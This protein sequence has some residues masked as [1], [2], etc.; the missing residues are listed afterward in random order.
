[1]A[2]WSRLEGLVGLAREHARRVRLLR[3][4][5]KKTGMVE[6]LS[7]EGLRALVR[8]RGRANTSLVYRYYAAA[9]AHQPALVHHERAYTFAELDSQIDA[10][11]AALRA[12]GIGRGDAVVLMLKNVPEFI[13]AQQGI[14]RIGAA[15]V[16]VSWRSTASELAYLVEHSGARALLF[17]ASTTDAVRGALERAGRRVGS[18]A[19]SVGGAVPGFGS[20]EELLAARGATPVEDASDEGAVVIYTS[21]TT[22]KPKGAVRKF[23]SNAMVQVLSFIAETPMRVGQTHL[24]VCP[25]YHS[26]GFGF[27]GLAYLLGSTVILHDGF[28]PHDF[29][30]ALERHRV[31]HT[32]LVPTMLHRAVALGED[33]IRARDTSHLKAIFTGGAPL[34]PA[35]ARGAMAAFGDKVF[36]FYGA[37]ETGLVTVAT[38]SD[39]RAAPGTIGRTIG[40]NEIA[41][42]AD[43]GRRCAPGEVGELYVRSG[44][45]VEGYHDDPQATAAS[46][47]DGFFTVGDLARQDERG[48][49]FLEGRKRDMIISGGVNVYPTE[50]ESVIMEHPAVA[51]AA[52]IG[53]HDDEWGERV[54]AFVELKSGARCSA[55]DLSAHCREHLSGPKRPRDF[56]LVDVLPRNPTGK[57]LKRELRERL[58]GATMSSAGRV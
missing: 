39:L 11:G 14:G 38:P 30:E 48:F 26:T 17:D 33:T 34:S 20:Y 5:A 49:F 45:L 22:G 16:S 43:E 50:V 2:R 25:L 6:D 18:R 54:C 56:V 4:V 8:A 58:A 31:D 53:V 1:M 57:I 21:G 41:L 12:Q 42:F 23:S 55:D 19:F 9:R 10:A 46:L 27:A 28:E 51:E 24:C 35:L 29:L 36:N 15:A 52:V 13:F 32:A 40:G 37:T 7:L 3:R 47:K 44:N